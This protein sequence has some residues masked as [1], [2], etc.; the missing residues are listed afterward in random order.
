MVEA[1]AGGRGRKVA[2]LRFS[3]WCG[4]RG[5]RVRKATERGKLEAR[6][7]AGSSGVW[8]AELRF[9]WCG[10][11]GLSQVV[12]RRLRWAGLGGGHGGVQ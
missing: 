10:G 11:R 12:L 4:G 6:L 7:Q 1:E 3:G 2:E 5:G 9:F 8:R